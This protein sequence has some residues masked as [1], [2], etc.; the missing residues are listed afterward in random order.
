MFTREDLINRSFFGTRCYGDC[1]YSDSNAYIL[2]FSYPRTTSGIKLKFYNTSGTKIGEIGSDIE[3]SKILDVD[4]ALEEFGCGKFSFVL[5]GSPSF[6]IEY[7]TRVD[8]HLFNDSDPW[9]S[10]YVMNLPITGS[11][12]LEYK[13]AGFGYY[14]QL[15]TCI[16]DKS[17]TNAE[18]SAIAKDIVAT[19]VEPGTDIVY[20]ATLFTDT[21]YTINS[22]NFNKVTAKKALNDLAEMAQNY[23]MG[24]GENRK[25]FF[26][27]VNTDVN[28]DAIRHVGKNLEKYKP[29]ED[30]SEILNKIYILAGLITDGSNY[31]CTVE[32]EDSQETY[33]VREGV[34]TIPSSLNV[35]DAQRWGNYKLS[36]LK[37]PVEKA[38]AEGI[39]LKQIVIKA[40]GKA[41]IFD[42]YGNKKEL[43]IKRV[44]YKVS[45]D[46]TICSMELGELDIPI[47][48]DILKILRDLKNE[49]ELQQINISQLV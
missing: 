44:S 30:T 34:L 48:K 6:T 5:S 38:V 26:K 19:F 4:F 18:I 9:Y 11:T 40:D 37:D 42:K 35:N 25:L 3:N 12:E 2:I 39:T 41:R 14:Y 43:Y 45:P 15:E 13:Y 17:Y 33:G 36:K 47:S 28:V 23:I 10:G 24:V 16:I 31:I 8:V 1:R 49:V 20:D 29:E 27:P 7:R 32:D 21:G 46:G 22:I